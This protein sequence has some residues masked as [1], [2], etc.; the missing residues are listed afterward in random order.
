MKSR[1][2]VVF[3]Q[4]PPP[5]H[6]QSRMV[7]EMLRVLSERDFGHVVHVNARFSFSLDEIGE[8]SLRKLIRSAKYI[9]QALRLRFSVKDPVLY[10]VPGP[11]KWSALVRDWMILGVLRL[12]YRRVVFH[13]H[14]I[15]QGEWAHGS[16]RPSLGGPDWLIGLG[17]ILSRAALHH[18]V[19]SIVVSET[20]RTDADSVSSACVRVVPNGIVDPLSTEG[21]RNKSQ[22][23]TPCMRGGESLQHWLFL[24]R[25]T[26]EKGL[27]DLF[28]AVVRLGSSEGLG[29][30]R[31]TLA[32]GLAP[33]FRNR[34]EHAVA[35]A[36]EAWSGRL[37]IV[38]IGFVTGDEKWQLYT[39]ADLFLAPS[40]WESFGLVVAEAMAMELPIVAAACDGIRGVL[41]VDY[42][43]LA[44]I[45]DPAGFADKLL[46]AS[47]LLES[48]EGGSVGRAL[49]RRFKERFQS[50]DFELG[51]VEALSEVTSLHTPSV[52]GRGLK[53]QAYLADQNPKLGRSLGISRMTEVVL[54]GIA[55]R[56]DVRLVGLESAS[57][58]PSPLGSVSTVRFPWS[59]R[60]KMIRIATDHL[61]PLFV[62]WRERADV[63]YYPKG[64]MPRFLMGCEPAVATIHDTIIQF[65]QDN[66]PKW[67]LE[68]EYSYWAGMLINTLKNAT[69]IMTVSENAKGQIQ[70]FI[71]RHGLPEREI[72]VTYEPCLYESLPQPIEP[73][74]AAYVLHLGSKEP[75]KRTAWL[76]KKWAEWAEQG[77]EWREGSILPKL[78]IVGSI[79]DEVSG[80]ARRSPSIV[81]LPFLEDEALISQ[82]LGARALLFP[83]EVEGF[84]LPAIEAYYL[85]TPVCFHRR[86]SVEEVLGVATH[87]GSFDPED[88]NGLLQAFREVMDM[89]PAEVRDCGLKLREA[90]S[91]KRVVER[92]MDV[93]RRAAGV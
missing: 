52:Q 6:G 54:G 3:A 59:T 17:R 57:S 48:G 62:S 64:F 84:G 16:N 28:D 9:L 61:H 46:L 58:V 10:Y 30:V 41:P 93:F 8:G 15:G 4:V 5:E 1:S 32:G 66:Y 67:R 69:A 31:L 87:K 21:T 74:K 80:L 81:Y 89:S 29:H 36:E 19:L 44:S 34:F 45:A 14:A 83:S 49:R 33:E 2:L 22:P 35:Q 39:Q 63:W 71:R 78:H 12:F 55:S 53:V 47:E 91:S 23:L 72:Y 25:G 37:Q 56:P 27:F 40:R 77:I 76:I 79:P 13:W 42:P 85:G 92:M 68:L 86:T 20:S 26:E 82:F 18:P 50:E 75:H 90:Y 11:V 38:E 88:D 7:A 60:S 24:S 70:E 43:Y 65:Y 73:A 51:I